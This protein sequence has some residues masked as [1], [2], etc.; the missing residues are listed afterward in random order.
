MHATASVHTS[1]P[2]ITDLFE[3]AL[4]ALDARHRIERQQLFERAS[5][6][7]SAHAALELLA[8]QG[9]D[10]TVRSTTT[11]GQTHA[12]GR[13]VVL[14]D[15]DAT[16]RTRLRRLLEG[17]AADLEIVAGDDRPH[18]V[19]RHAQGWLLMVSWT[20]EAESTAQEAAA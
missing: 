5:E 2:I 20:G 17:P 12:D 9:I 15:L 3:H 1:A 11:F 16:R 14:A 19:F 4:D 8:A 10:A 18:T 6:F 13:L 7:A